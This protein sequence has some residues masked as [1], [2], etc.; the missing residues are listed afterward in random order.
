MI[1][2]LVLLVLRTHE[3]L[4]EETLIVFSTQLAG[5]PAESAVSTLDGR[6]V[7]S[8]Q[9]VGIGWHELRIAHPKS[10]PFSTNLFIWYGERDLDRITLQRGYGV[11]ALEVIPL[12]ARV[13]V[14]G[15]DFKIDRKSVV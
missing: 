15:P 6:T 3:Q 2:V 1:L 10:E 13:S 14:I 12:A 9:R 8:G 5:K 7:Q 11:I 4:S